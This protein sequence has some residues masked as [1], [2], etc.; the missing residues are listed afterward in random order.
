MKTSYRIV[1]IRHEM[2]H[3]IHKARFSWKRD[4]GLVADSW[5]RRYKS[6]LAWMFTVSATCCRYWFVISFYATRNA[7]NSSVLTDVY[8]LTDGEY[9][10]APTD[11]LIRFCLSKFTIIAGKIY[12][13]TS[14]TLRISTYAPY[15][16][17][18]KSIY[19]ILFRWTLWQSRPNKAGLKCPSIRTYVRPSVHKSFFDF[20]EIWHVG[21]GRWVM[22][23]GMQYDPIQGQGHEPFKVGNPVIFN[24]Y[25]LRHL[26]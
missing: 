22:H 26:Q 20:N 18:L 15:T 9:V 2:T 4:S 25:L 19:F 8:V 14:W 17:A 11:D 1:F 6:W 5:R 24:S 21:R 12:M 7:W 3:N 23:N 16:L 13:T 10:L